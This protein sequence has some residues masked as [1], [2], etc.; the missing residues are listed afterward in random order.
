M[1]ERGYVILAGNQKEYRQAA[2]LAY[3]IKS[4]MP[5]ESVTLVV[6]DSK[7]I[8]NHWLEAIDNVVEFPFVVKEYTRQNDWQLY[9]ASPYKYTIALDC[10]M[11]IKEDHTTLWDYLIDHHDVCFSVEQ[12]DFMGRP[13]ESKLKRAINEEYPQIPNLGSSMFFFVK[14]T[15]AALQYFKYA[16]VLMQSWFETLTHFVKNQYYTEGYDADVMHM[17]IAQHFDN[18]IFPLHKQILSYVD[19]KSTLENKVLGKWERWTDRINVWSSANAKIKIQNF[20]ITTNLYYHEDEFLTEEIFNEHRE[21][22]RTVNKV[23][24]KMVDTVQ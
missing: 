20:A 18:H 12:R 11:L 6:P 5:K 2:A 23:S 4:K 7:I 10:K 14:D 21:Y 1:N 19:M 24:K 13:V 15:D 3:S 8:D 16:D 9:W 17:L 22:Y